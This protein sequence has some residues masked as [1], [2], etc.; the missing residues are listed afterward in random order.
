MN[1]MMLVTVV[2][3]FISFSVGTIFGWQYHQNEVNSKLRNYEWMQ[4]TYLSK[5]G[6]TALWK[7]G[8]TLNYHLMSFDSGKNWYAIDMDSKPQV[9]ILGLVETV[10]PGLLE[11]LNATS[12]LTDY[13]WKNGSINLEDN[14]GMALLKNAGFSVTQK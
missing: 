12:T 6:G 2:I 7:E 4:K 1:T 9:K 14:I 13:V 10:Y 8:I 5:Q 3:V 11:C